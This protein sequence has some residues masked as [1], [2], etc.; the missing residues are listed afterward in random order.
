MGILEV[1]FLTLSHLLT[2]IVSMIIRVIIYNY[3][4]KKP[5]GTVFENHHKKS[6]HFY[7]FGL[8]ILMRHFD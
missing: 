5:P 4:T 1:G 2:C 6:N 8:K 7:I 3:L